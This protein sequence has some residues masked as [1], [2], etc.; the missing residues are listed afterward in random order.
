MFQQITVCHIKNHTSRDYTNVTNVM[1]VNQI[2]VNTFILGMNLDNRFLLIVII[3]F[4]VV[5]LQTPNAVII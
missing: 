3:T 5:I 2:Y 4:S 1:L